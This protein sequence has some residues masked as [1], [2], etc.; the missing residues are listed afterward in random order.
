MQPIDWLRLFSVVATAC[1]VWSLWRARPKPVLID[2]RSYYRQPDGGWRTVWGRRVRD[3]ALLD[4]LAAATD[5]RQ[6]G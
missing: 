3:P 1:A 6:G 2:G 5:T 4:A